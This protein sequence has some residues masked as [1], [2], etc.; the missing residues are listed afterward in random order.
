MIGFGLVV[1]L[2]LFALQQNINLFYTP[3]ELSMSRIQPTT[4]IR[5]GGM[6][7]IGSLE[8]AA[9]LTVKF[10]VTDYHHDLPVVYDGV[11]PDLF[12][13]GQGVVALGVLGSDH[14]FQAEQILAKHDENYMPPEL[15]NIIK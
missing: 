8:Q 9:G 12:R 14:V 2:V 4:R 5:I 3:Q 1:A 6:V 15:A 13:E 10:V 11:L 7:K